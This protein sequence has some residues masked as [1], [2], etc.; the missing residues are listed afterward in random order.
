MKKTVISILGSV[1]LFSQT[2]MFSSC[3]TASDGET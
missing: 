1:F 2:L 3:D